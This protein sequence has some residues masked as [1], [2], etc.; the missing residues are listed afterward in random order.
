MYVYRAGS[1]HIQVG[2]TNLL[3][4]HV[5]VTS[6][7]SYEYLFRPTGVGQ[8]V[9]EC[10]QQDLVQTGCYMYIR[11][12]I[13]VLHTRTHITDVEKCWKGHFG[14]RRR[15]RSEQYISLAGVKPFSSVQET[16]VYFFPHHVVSHYEAPVFI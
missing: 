9:G 2:A 15:E 4:V 1:R 16:H 10:C 6:A 5:A 3:Y 13:H 7:R 8:I 12:R 14:E 11:Y